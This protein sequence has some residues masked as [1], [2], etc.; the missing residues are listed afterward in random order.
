M[1]GDFKR[2]FWIGAGVAAALI[3]VG[4]LAGIVQTAL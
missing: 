1:S 3:V 4:F 2:G